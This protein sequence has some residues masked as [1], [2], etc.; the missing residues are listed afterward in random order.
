MKFFSHSQ[1]VVLLLLALL[2]LGS[3]CLKLYHPS[4]TASPVQLHREIPIEVQGDVRRPGVYLF[5]SPPAA[6]E[7]ILRAGGIRDV[8]S[9][10]LGTPSEALGAGT[11]LTVVQ[12]AP[13]EIKVKLGR[14]EARKLLVFSIPVDLN[15]A[16]EEDLCLVPGIGPQ[17][18]RDIVAHRRA[19]GGFRSVEELRNI[20]GIGPK[21]Y[22]LLRDF[23]T[24]HPDN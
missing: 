8:P 12:T 1:Q 20:K 7:V 13:D 21:N 23:F 17:I 16:S 5:E 9:L 14:M 2:I 3:L 6:K 11:L 19:R 22:P 24:V 18:A 15:R 10:D 4:P